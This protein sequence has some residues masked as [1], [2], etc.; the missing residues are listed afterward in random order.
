MQDVLQQNVE[1]DQELALL[2]DQVAKISQ[3]SPVKAKRGLLAN[4]KEAVA[5]PQKGRMTRRKTA[6]KLND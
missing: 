6:K 3:K 5:T 4:L 2:K 1:K